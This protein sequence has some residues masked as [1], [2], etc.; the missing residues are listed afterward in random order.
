MAIKS[1]IKLDPEVSIENDASSVVMI[2]RVSPGPN[3]IK[4]FCL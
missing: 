1:Y 4:L 2:Q 3:V